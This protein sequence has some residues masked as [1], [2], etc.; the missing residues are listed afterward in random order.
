MVEGS[1]PERIGFLCMTIG[2]GRFYD[3]ASGL[4]TRDA[5]NFMVEH[6]LRNAL[7]TQDFL[8]L[9]VVIAEREWQELVVAAD[10]WIVKELARLIRSAIRSTDLLSRTADGMLSLL[11]V[12]I[13]LERAN[14][15]IARLNDHLRR[16]GASPNLLISV[17]AACCP[18][19]SIS[20][21]E[22]LRKALASR[23][24]PMRRAS[25][26]PPESTGTA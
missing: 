18:T 26:V 8:T 9:V 6:Q 10:E 12:G 21:D 14:A 25:R 23:S 11:L 16:Y 20:A 1:P 5:F 7:R 24:A 15:V 19:H 4:L 13:D 22:L 3:A 17:G 2:H